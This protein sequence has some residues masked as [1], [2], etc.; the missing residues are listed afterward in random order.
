MTLDD[1]EDARIVALW[2][3][4]VQQGDDTPAMQDLTTDAIAALARYQRRNA[5]PQ[6]GV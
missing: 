4:R 6:G 5:A 2:L 3:D 1:H